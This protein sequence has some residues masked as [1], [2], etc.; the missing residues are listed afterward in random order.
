MI[1]EYLNK[2]AKDTLWVLALNAVNFSSSFIIAV[3][4]SRMMG[5][6]ELGKYTFITA[7]SS[8]LYMIADFGL[9]TSLVRKIGGDRP[10]A[11]KFISEANSIKTFSGLLQL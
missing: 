2:I 4:I 1:K 5:V 3:F 10:D 8:V 7:I 6:N 9:T 11:F